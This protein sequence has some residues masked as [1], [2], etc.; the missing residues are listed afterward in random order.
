MIAGLRDLPPVEG[1]ERARALA[2]EGPVTLVIEEVE[3]LWAAIDRDDDW[4]PLEAKI[5]G[6][7]TA[8]ALNAALGLLRGPHA[9]PGHVP[10]EP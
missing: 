8:G 1:V 9:R 7:R 6:I 10:L 5:A 3:A 2:G 4:A